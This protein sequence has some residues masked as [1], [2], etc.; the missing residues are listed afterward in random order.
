MPEHR[1]IFFI[2]D[3]KLYVKFKQVPEVG[4][5]VYSCILPNGVQTNQP[6]FSLCSK[7][8]IQAH[9]HLSGNLLLF[10]VM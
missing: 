7:Q 2:N 6:R 5:I 10:T 9:N 3:T 1:M 8:S 4:Y